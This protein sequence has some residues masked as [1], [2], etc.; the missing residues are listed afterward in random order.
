MITVTEVKI[1][2]TADVEIDSSITLTTVEE[3]FK[4]ELEKYFKENAYNN[5]KISIAKVQ[6]ILMSLSGVTDCSNVLINGKNTNIIL[7]EEETSVL[8]SVSLGVM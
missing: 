8:N 6:S 1:N 5:K 7:K 4:R 3:S 2:I